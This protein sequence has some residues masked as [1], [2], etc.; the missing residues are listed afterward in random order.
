MVKCDC[1]F[2]TDSEILWVAHIIKN[3]PDRIEER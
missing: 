1:G 3:H 2:E